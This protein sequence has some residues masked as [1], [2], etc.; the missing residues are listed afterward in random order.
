MILKKKTRGERRRLS[1]PL[2]ERER[3]RERD[4]ETEER[5]RE[6]VTFIVNTTVSVNEIHKKRFAFPPD[7]YLWPFDCSTLLLFYISVE[8]LFK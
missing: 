3:E 7:C 2:R 5:E 8:L 6:T 1:I 4:R